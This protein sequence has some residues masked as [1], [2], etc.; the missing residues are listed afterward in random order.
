VVVERLPAAGESIWQSQARFRSLGPVIPLTLPGDV[1]VWAA[2]SHAAVREVLSGDDRVFGKHL[3][4]W[5]AYREGSVAEDWALIPLL[6]NEHMLMQDGAVHAR[7]RRLMSAAFTPRRV[8]A[9]QPFVEHV[10]D[11]LLNRMDRTVDLVPDFA[12]QVPMAVICE[13]FGVPLSDRE[14]LRT[15]TSTQ[16]STMTTPTQA[17]GAARDLAAYLARLV[18]AKRGRDEDD[19]TTALIR[20]HDDEGRLSLRELVDSLRLMLIAGHETTLHLIG[21][22]VIALL[23]HPDQLKMVMEFQRWPDA[24]EETLRRHTPVAGSAFRYALRDTTVAGVEIAA[25]DAI[26]LC[27]NGAATDPAVYGEDAACFDV[28]RPSQSHLAFSYGP[29]FCLG[30]PLARLEG[31]TA[32]SRLFRRF[33]DMTLTVDPDEIPHTPSFITNGP[34]SVPVA[35]Y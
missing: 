24:V 4:R 20:A 10:V 5:R 1:V 11:D 21:S 32:L 3:S 13:L 31:R 9:L 2:T 30:A 15:W 14:D 35:L 12:E 26:Y 8:Q 6:R 19:L 34:M 33:P 27:Y 28:D 22:A 17:A 23:T 7:L 25:G 16:F 18:K 29:H